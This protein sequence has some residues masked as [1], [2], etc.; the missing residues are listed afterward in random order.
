ME[1]KMSPRDMLDSAD[2]RRLV[3]R[4]WTVSV[5]LSLALFVTYYGYILLVAWNKP[6]LSRKLGPVVTLG[7]PVGV[8]VILVSWILTALYVVWANRTFDVEVRRLRDKLDGQ[9]R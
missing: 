3:A 8:A 4:R 5:V 7:I 9:E 2:F 6:L 1:E